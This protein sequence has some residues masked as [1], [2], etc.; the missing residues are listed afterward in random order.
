M[1]HDFRNERYPAYITKGNASSFILPFARE[2]CKGRGLDI[3]GGRYPFP[4]ATNIDIKTGR[5]AMTI[6]EGPF[7]FIFSSHCLEHLDDPAGA[8]YH[9]TA[10]IKDG[11]IL[12]LYLPHPS[13]ALWWPEHNRAHKHIL[14]PEAIET[15]LRSY[16]YTDIMATGKDLY[17]SFAV[18][19]RKNTGVFVTRERLH[20]LPTVFKREPL[21]VKTFIAQEE[22]LRRL[23]GMAG[24]LFVIDELDLYCPE[25]SGTEI[26][27]VTRECEGDPPHFISFQRCKNCGFSRESFTVSGKGHG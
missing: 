17:W 24:A 13:A 5:D 11:G 16:G 9:W 3:G 21:D 25:C 12:F 15:V 18:V 2:F 20:K 10:Q 27:R 6:P 1:Y 22:R 4:G 19:A 14:E 8:L 23:K 26:E 7:D